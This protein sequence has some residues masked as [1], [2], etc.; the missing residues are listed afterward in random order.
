[1]LW[2][3]GVDRTG[4]G[5]CPITAFGGVA[6]NLLVLL[7][8]LASHG[9][10]HISN[11]HNCQSQW[12]R[13]LRHELSPLARTL[14]SWVRITLK[15]WM[16]NVCVYS[17]F[18]L[19]CVGRSL[20]S[21]YRLCIGSRNWKSGQGSTKGCRAITIIMIIII[22]MIPK[23]NYTQFNKQKRLFVKKKS[24]KSMY[25]SMIGRPLWSSGQSSWLQIQRTWVRF[26]ALPDFWEVVGLERGPLSLMRI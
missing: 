19:F 20:A 7:L 4:S 16:L 9:C 21:G 24:N 26:P 6:F 2:G 5:S 10:I 11:L 22:C 23:F 1:M 18:V 25:I 3:L 15:A 14:G 13:G 8:R 17:V 12:P